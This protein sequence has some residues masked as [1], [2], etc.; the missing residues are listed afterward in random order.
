MRG[1]MGVLVVLLVC[2]GIPASLSGQEILPADPTG[3][4]ESDFLLEQNYPNP[5]NPETKIPFVLDEDLFASGGPVVVTLRVYNVLQQFVA[6]PTALNH[7][8]G[9]GTPVN[10]LEY[11]GSGRY[12]AYWDGRDRAGREVASGVYFLQLVVNGRAQ[13][14]KMFVTK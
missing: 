2:L 3:R 1:V 14:R 6:T 9:E 7:P 13:V 10:E 8:R 11:P 5:F 4:Q 12:E